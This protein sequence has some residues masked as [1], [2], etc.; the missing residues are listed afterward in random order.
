MTH[1]ALNCTL[2]LVLWGTDTSGEDDVAVFS[3]IL[4]EREG[5]AYLHRDSG[6]VPLEIEWLERIAAVP[7][8]LRPTLLN[9]EYQLSLSVGDID[10][11][12][13]ASWK[14]L[15]LKWPT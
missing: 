9:C 13:S 5:S 15:G 4:V 14:A 8:D 11:E 1:S 6:D 2:A 12:A 7:T 3:G 10:D